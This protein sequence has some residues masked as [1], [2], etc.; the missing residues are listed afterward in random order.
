MSPQ[1]YDAILRHIRTTYNSNFLQNYMDIVWNMMTRQIDYQELY[2]LVIQHL[3]DITPTDKKGAVLDYWNDRC[4]NY[5]ESHAWM[6]ANDLLD[7]ITEEYDEFCDYIKWKK[8][9]A[10]S[11]TGWLRLMRNGIVQES[12]ER[13]FDT[14][15]QQTD[16]AIQQSSHRLLDCFLEWLLRMVGVEV[17]YIYPGSYSTQLNDWMTVIKDRGLS[18]ALRFKIIDILKSMEV[19]AK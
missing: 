12:Y 10:A 19:S 9:T 16:E 13:C 18:S 14:I 3:L 2:I 5:F 6:P 7:S 11:L 15:M 4:K 17:S 8:H 1:N